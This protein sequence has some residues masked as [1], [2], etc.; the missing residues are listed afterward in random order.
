M[1][2]AEAAEAWRARGERVLLLRTETSPEDVGGMNAG[3]CEAQVFPTLD[4]A[5]S[6]V[7]VYSV[8]CCCVPTPEDVGGMNVGQSGRA[9][10]RGEAEV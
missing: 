9:I 4:A 3:G 8:Y 6:G 2:T 7:S 5:V 10:Y 1:F